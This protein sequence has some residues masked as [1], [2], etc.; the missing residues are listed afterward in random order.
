MSKLWNKEKRAIAEHSE[1]GACKR[2]CVADGMV[3][4]GKTIDFGRN[5]FYKG[6]NK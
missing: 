1:R 2:K 6:A 4:R 5:L 3:T